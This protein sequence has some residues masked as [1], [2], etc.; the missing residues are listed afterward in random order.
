[1]DNI[2]RGLQNQ[3]CLIYLDD[4]IVFSTSLQ[5]HMVNLEKVFQRLRD[6]NFKIQMDKSEFLKMETAYL[7]HIIGRDG[8]RPNPDKIIAA[9]LSGL[10]LT[11]QKNTLYRNLRG[12]LNNSWDYWVII[13]NSYRISRG[14]QSHLRSV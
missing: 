12:K 8:V 10:G 5:E 4:I 13:G 2:L 11:P 1:M 9:I 3:I 6:S 14:L 7:G